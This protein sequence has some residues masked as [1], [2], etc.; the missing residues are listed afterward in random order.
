MDEEQIRGMISG[1]ISGLHEALR[2][3]EGDRTCQNRAKALEAM[4]AVSRVVLQLAL[5]ELA[6][7]ILACSEGA[8]WHG[9]EAT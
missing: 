9:S 3:Y 5:E 8:E 7:D 2:E 6:R 1:P 4:N